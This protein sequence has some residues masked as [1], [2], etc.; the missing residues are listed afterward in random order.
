MVLSGPH[1]MYVTT[2]SY[3]TNPEEEVYYG[4]WGKQILTL[5]TSSETSETTVCFDDDCKPCI[6]DHR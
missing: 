5:K 1:Q 3:M 2:A 6:G 4:Y